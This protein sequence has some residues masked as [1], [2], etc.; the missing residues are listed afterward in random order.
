MIDVA[1]QVAHHYTHGALL[2]AILQAL[3]KAGKDV[4]RLHRGDLAA[5]DEFH[6]GWAAATVDL[7]KDLELSPANRVLDIGSG[8]GGPAR[9]FAETF[10]A[11]VT[12]IDL[13][14]EYVDVAN[15]LTKRCGLADRAVFRQASALDLPFTR[16][17]FDRASL[18]HVGMNIA[19]KATLFG[20]VRRVLEPGALFL[21][22]DI[23]KTSKADLPYPM[24]WAATPET[25]FVETPTTYGDLLAK[26]GFEIDGETDRSEMALALGKQMRENVERNGVPPLGLHTLMGPATPQRIGNVMASLAAG[27]IAPIQMLA[28]AR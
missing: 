11:H 22:Y 2:E 25:S 16:N 28:R 18:I 8:L 13:T 27:T 24:P 5:A 9:H 7:A 26:N 21:V 1:T 10:G 17:S 4:D 6:L 19:D 23:M 15:E 12:G 20:E 3:R 14:Q